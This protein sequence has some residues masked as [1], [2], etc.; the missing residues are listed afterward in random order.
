[1]SR[2][3]I[4][5]PVRPINDLVEDQEPR[6]WI[7]TGDDPQFYLNLT[8]CGVHF[9]RGWVHIEIDLAFIEN[10]RRP[11]LLW[12][13][14]SGFSEEKSCFMALPVEGRTSVTLFF[15]ESLRALR[16]DPTNCAARFK[17]S[18][19]RLRQVSRYSAVMSA[20][21]PYAGRAIRRPG[22]YGRFL[23][24]VFELWRLSGTTAV[25]LAARE[26]ITT[27]S[28]ASVR[29]YV[30][31]Q[32]AFARQ[33]HGRSEH[34]TGVS[35]N[36][37]ARSPQKS[38]KRRIVVGLV[39]HFGDIVACEPVVRYLRKEYPDAEISWAVR[40][41]F[42]EII[43]S[44]PDIDNTI[45]VDC[46]TDWMQCR[47]HGG[48]DHVI[49]LHVN[50]RICQHCRIPLNKVHGDTSI[51]GDNHFSHGSLLQALCKG[52]G[53]PLLED[54]PRV[55][56]PE[57]ARNA[58]N[59]YGLP[60]RYVV[61]HAKSN[62][63][64]KDW[65]SA[66]WSELARHVIRM[67]YHVVEI[68]L[69]PS[70]ENV[71][72]GYHDLCGKTSLLE[73]AE[74]IRR[75]ELLVAVESGPAHFANAVGGR[76]VVVIGQFQ[77]FK[78]Y[79]PYS[80]NFG[81]GVNVWFARNTEGP[82]ASLELEPVLERVMAVLASD[83]APRSGASVHPEAVA[84]NTSEIDPRLIAFYLPQFHPIPQNDRAWGKGFTE[85][86]NVGSARPFF[87]AQ[88]QPRLPG[89][90]GYYDLRVPE[91]MEQ[92]AELARTHG[93]HG[94]CYYYYW[95]N[96]TRLLNKPLDAMLRSRKPDFPF[97]FCWANE[98]W[99]RRWDGMSKEIIVAQNHNP[100]DDLAF[101]RS[102]F[103]AFED[104]RYIRVNGKPLL[105]IYRTDLFPD[106][107]KTAE[108]WR[109]EARKAGFDD[110]YLVRCESTDPF[111][112]PDSIGFD[113]SYEVPTFILPD[114]LRLDD[115]ASLNVSPE[116]QG[117][118]FDYEKIVDYY[119]RRPNVPYKRYRDP[120]LAWDNTARHG[121][122][123]VVFHGV[124]PALYEKWMR[125]CYTDARRKFV[126][127]ERLVFVNAWNEWAEGSYLEPDLRYGREF[128]EATAR[129][130][131]ISRVDA[132]SSGNESI[133]PVHRHSVFAHS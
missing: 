70:V 52:A 15:H 74:V 131:T 63:M 124:S 86:R 39:E 78:T 114:E 73:A 32:L 9:P 21:W 51:T 77:R 106:P 96:G 68:G 99:T 31:T 132:P 102:L 118:I 38:A 25:R 103:V 49:D 84:A 1:M 16:I 58:V 23:R 55:Y 56:I 75:G 125:D 111:T 88:Y 18:H 27:R 93:I 22:L 79:N 66:H 41:V 42:R 89:E 121:N 36:R 64:E 101:I 10:P 30:G 24:D 133:S 50:G 112:T 72:A 14:G 34:G 123:A 44:H 130:V 87:E 45:A 85:W 126:G 54:A 67:G 53:L 48:F 60:E 116:F 100:A 69:S 81:R 120:M 76:A 13:N 108:L 128:L 110:L 7:A 28:G 95:F 29:Q 43:D 62:A 47:A 83:V 104:S 107:A 12:D 20:V 91:I 65:N 71:G 97:S 46:L 35:R 37:R 2:A 11:Q 19:L 115:L 5:L 40:H 90:L 33:G 92:Q 98:N 94:F 6:S 17:L 61:F 119:C 80:G 105:L 122:R 82:A 4:S 8:D 26:M 57:V 129:A 113:A 109:N 127:E 117:R 59:G 3:W